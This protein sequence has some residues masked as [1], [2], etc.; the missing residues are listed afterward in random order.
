[1]SGDNLLSQV[2]QWGEYYWHLVDRGHRCCQTSHTVQGQAPATNNYTTPNVNN[3]EEVEKFSSRLMAVQ[4]GETGTSTTYTDSGFILCLD[5]LSRR[6]ADRLVQMLQCSVWIPPEGLGPGRPICVSVCLPCPQRIGQTITTP[7]SL[8]LGHW[9]DVQI[10]ANNLSVEIKKRKWQTLCTS[11][12]PTFN[13][14]WPRDGTFNI[15]VILQVKERIFSQGPQGHPDQVPYIVVWESLIND[16][17]PWVSPF[18]HPKPKPIPDPIPLP[19]PS[20]PPVPLCPA[21]PPKPPVPLCPAETLKPPVP[22]CPA[23]PS[24]PPVSSNLYPVIGDSVSSRRP[25][26]KR[27]LPPDDSPLIDLLTEDPPPY[28]HPPLPAQAPTSSDSEEEPDNP[29]EECHPSQSPI[30]GRLRG[31]K[32]AIKEGSSKLLPLR[33]GGG[34]AGNQLQ[35]W[36]FSASDLYKW[37]S[38]NPSFSQDPIALTALIESILIT[39]QP[40]WDDCQQLLQT[41]LITEERQKVYLE[42]RKNVPG[43]NGRP[44]QLPNMIDAAFPLTRPDWDFNT[45]E[46]R[47]HLNLYHQLLIA[48]LHNAGR[49][50]TNLAQVRQVTQGSKES[51]TAFLERLKEAYRRYTPFDPDSHE[52][53]GNV[54]M[55]FIWQSAP[56]IRHKLQQLENL[57]DFS[58]QDLLKEAEKIYSKRETQEEKED[59]LRKEA[60]EKEDK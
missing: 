31:H 51:P 60:E 57:Q 4:Q 16:P 1:M 2:G 17:P 53:R 15:T 20:A 24:K 48:G 35:Y 9:R 10:R 32:E 27:V 47:T 21:E 30:A 37:K 19:T 33:Q 11:E 36:P 5:L 38:H 13:V 26:P 49:R 18:N 28:Q 6:V 23:H 8:T 58:L 46:G 14:G 42:A 56:D 59:R 44:T 43:D 52:Q 25:K 50:P 55:A 3:A 54:S 7:L 29:P 45:A 22:L 40:T 12:W 39:H 34:G 41:L